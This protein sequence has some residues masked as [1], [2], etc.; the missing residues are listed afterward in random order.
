MIS[1]T[2]LVPTRTIPNMNGVREKSLQVSFPR[3][4]SLLLD[5]DTL[6]MLARE[7]LDRFDNVAN[8]RL[9]YDQERS[10]TGRRVRP[11]DDEIVGEARDRM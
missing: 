8:D 11:A 5:L 3:C 6:E 2:T 10:S 9:E 1:F 4:Q 7:L